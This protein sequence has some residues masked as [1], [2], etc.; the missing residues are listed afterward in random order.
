MRYYLLS[1]F[2]IG[3]LS[4]ATPV[5]AEKVMRWVDQD[6]ITHFGNTPPVGQTNVEEVH[7]QP[8]NKADV[9]TRKIS[10]SLQAAFAAVQQNKKT[11]ATRPSNVVIEGPP[12]KEL[13][14]LARP[15]SK[16]SNRSYRSRSRVR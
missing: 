5:Q 8:T 11:S 1:L 9:P 4:V 10:S 6:G 16:R 3:Y 12:Q 2:V 15:S 14:P 7:V 13:T